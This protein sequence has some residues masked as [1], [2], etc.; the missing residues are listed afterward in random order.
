[1][2]KKTSRRGRVSLWLIIIF[3]ILAIAIFIFLYLDEK[4]EGSLSLNPK[5]VPDT[6]INEICLKIFYPDNVYYCLA[7]VNQDASYC[8]DLDT[9]AEKK[10][11]QA[12]AA[13]DAS[14]C[15]EI[16][17]AEPKKVCYY[18]V[19]FLTGEFDYCEEAENPNQCYF[20]F[21]YRLHWQSRANEI[22]AEYCQKFNENVSG[23]QVFKNCCLAFKEQNSSLC[24][25]N[26]YC[27]SFFKQPLSFCDTEFELPGGGLVNKDECLLHRTLSEKDS[28]ICA[29]IESEEGRDMCYADMSTHIS[30]NL[31]F[32]DKIINKMIRDMCYAEAAIYFAEH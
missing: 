1:M 29:K 6:A 20:A 26:R 9:P 17:E 28:S 16:Q 14:Y 3:L 27:L 30:P 4:R 23:G 22:K 10:L 31:S 18:E 7:A 25:G 13:R 2:K 12:T 5:D 32:C 11:C 21:V 15:R 24:Q 8:Q 19:G